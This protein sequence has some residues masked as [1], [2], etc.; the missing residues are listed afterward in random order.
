MVAWPTPG[1]SAAGRRES[2]HDRT[3]DQHHPHARPHRSPSSNERD[4]C[5]ITT[6]AT[7]ARTRSRAEAPGGDLAAAGSPKQPLDG[8]DLAA[9]YADEQPP[10]C[11]RRGRGGR[12]DP[13]RRAGALAAVGAAGSPRPW[14]SSRERQ[15]VM[16]PPGSA[17]RARVAQ[18]GEVLAGHA[19]RQ[20]AVFLAAQ[21]AAAGE[22]AAEAVAARRGRV[23]R[24]R[25]GGNV[26]RRL[27]AQAEVGDEAGVLAAAHV[28]PARPAAI[29]RGR[30]S[31]AR[32]R[33]RAPRPRITPRSG[34]SR[35]GAAA[36]WDPRA[37]SP[38]SVRQ[39]CDGGGHGGREQPAAAGR[40]LGASRRRQPWVMNADERRHAVG[41]ERPVAER[42]GVGL[43]GDVAAG[44]PTRCRGWAPC[45][46]DRHAAPNASPARRRARRITRRAAARRSSRAAGTPRPSR[47]GL[48]R[49]RQ[50]RCR[51]GRSS[52]SRSPGR[53]RSGRRRRRAGAG[54]VRER[55][56]ARRVAAFAHDD[57]AGGAA[58]LGHSR[59]HVVGADA[60]DLA[61][62]PSSSA[63]SSGH[64]GA[65][66]AA[67]AGSSMTIRNAV[68][69]RVIRNQ[70]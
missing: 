42:A 20:R 66:A 70:C 41:G 63:L 68:R 49:R 22:R 26:R 13:E 69:S 58:A 15:E 32:R 8:E 5:T 67:V 16:S 17:S 45:A 53:R 61:R 14:A 47:C 34:P 48:A 3:H 60:P 31:R 65:A 9:R 44:A 11:P 33:C 39:A 24:A 52:P 43:A 19:D 59:D 30:G 36:S 1:P 23:Y 27:Q 18:A 51:A 57:P 4:P 6:A 10:R 38:A 40:S 7:A 29:S 2:Q 35:G 55:D 64:E 50:G 21:R 54:D 46:G 28:V 62:P 56:R 12:G 25:P 37:R